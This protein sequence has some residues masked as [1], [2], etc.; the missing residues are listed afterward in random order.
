[1]NDEVCVQYI[2]NMMIEILNFH[3]IAALRD[4]SVGVYYSQKYENW[5]TKQAHLRLLK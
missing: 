3:Y 2:I 4:I 5:S 1:M